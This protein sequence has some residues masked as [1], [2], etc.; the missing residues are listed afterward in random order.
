METNTIMYVRS[1]FRLKKEVDENTITDV[2]NF[3]RLKKEIDEITQS[4]HKKLKK[5]ENKGVKDK[6]LRD[7]RNL[8]E[9]EVKDYYKPVR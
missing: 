4:K 2:K 6:I 7:I 9:Q 3:F 5:K 1:L 8:F